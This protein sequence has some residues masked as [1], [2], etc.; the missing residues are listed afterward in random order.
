MYLV[1]EQNDAAPYDRYNRCRAPR[2]R[3]FAPKPRSFWTLLACSL[4]LCAAPLA[5]AEERP[6]NDIAVE[7]LPELELTEASSALPL[8]LDTGASAPCLDTV[9]PVVALCPEHDEWLISSR[10]S[11]TCGDP[12]VGYEM[13]EYWRGDGN[14]GWIA[15]TAE[16]FH[17]T[18]DPRVPT[19]FFVHG[20]RVSRGEAKQM[21][22]QWVRRFEGAEY[23]EGPARLVIFTWPSDQIARKPIE[24]VRVKAQRSEAH[25]WYLAA[26]V[27]SI[28]SDVPVGLIGYSYGARLISA[29][30][31]L[32]GGGR[33]AGRQLVREEVPSPRP[34]RAVLLAAA[35]DHHW[36]GEGQH[37]GLALSQVDSLIVFVNREDAL[38]RLYPRL[39]GRGGP[40]ALG[41]TGVVSRSR[42]GVHGSKLRQINVAGAVGKHHDW[43]SYVNSGSIMNR[44]RRE[45]AFDELKVAAPPVEQ[46]PPPEMPM[47][48]TSASPALNLAN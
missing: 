35:L 34:L 20:N 42:L 15:A 38:L 30:L 44:A 10:R 27:D 4:L 29:S 36:L 40:D 24:D 18:D 12:L 48:A 45:F 28:P 17:A 23:G 8:P 46:D 26:L 21:G 19:I 43:Q 3:A 7:Q 31:H 16:E 39:F 41:R 2:P 14:C 32:L 1:A 33:I 9:E 11:S 22:R 6:A 37:H 47:A 5:H 13:L 25:A